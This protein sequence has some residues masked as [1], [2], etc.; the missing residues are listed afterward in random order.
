MINDENDQNIKNGNDDQ[1]M[2]EKEIKERYK[3]LKKE[4]VDHILN[5]NEKASTEEQSN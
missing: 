4:L 2:E 1:Q 5:N 3:E